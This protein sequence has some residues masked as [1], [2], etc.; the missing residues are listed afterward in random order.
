MVVRDRELADPATVPDA[1][2]DRLAEVPADVD[3]RE[4]VLPCR[5]GEARALAAKDVARVGVTIG[6]GRHVVLATCKDVAPG[7]GELQV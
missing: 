1:V 2:V 5:M 4:P 7:H 3:P 6:S